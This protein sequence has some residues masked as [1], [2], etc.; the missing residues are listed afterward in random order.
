M[1]IFIN[2][3]KESA[4]DV[5]DEKTKYIVMSREENTGKNYIIDRKKN[6]LRV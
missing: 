1:L 4:L 3:L 2:S 6:H 5:N